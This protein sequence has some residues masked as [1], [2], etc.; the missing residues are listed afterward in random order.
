MRPSRST[1]IAPPSG[2]SSAAQSWSIAWD[3]VSIQYSRR[4]RILACL[5]KWGP[6]KGTLF[7][8]EERAPPPGRHDES[9]TERTPHPNR[10]RHP[11]GGA[12]PALLAA[13]P[14]FLGAA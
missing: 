11:D 7:L 6:Q 4:C 8:I 10:P 5:L 9:R 13:D 2:T 1:L 3:M 12:F 14:S